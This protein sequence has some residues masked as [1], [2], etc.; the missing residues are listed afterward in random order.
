MVFG[1][2]RFL[3]ERLTYHSRVLCTWI[4]P[5]SGYMSVAVSFRAR[6]SPDMFPRRVS[7]G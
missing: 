3:Y 7:D 4:L 5:R 6:K 2:A 1:A